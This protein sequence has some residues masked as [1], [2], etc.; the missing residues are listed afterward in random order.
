M[1][2]N[3]SPQPEVEGVLIIP[4]ADFQ[5]KFF[6]FPSV[7][8]PS[9]GYNS[10]FLCLIQETLMESV[11]DEPEK[12]GLTPFFPD[13]CFILTHSLHPTVLQ[14]CEFCPRGDIALLVIILLHFT[15]EEPG[16]QRTLSVVRQPLS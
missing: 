16:P 6:P 2:C 1:A 4:S 15:D 9:S 10:F 11:S 3:P 13:T 12:M 8:S 14:P 7:A 5:L